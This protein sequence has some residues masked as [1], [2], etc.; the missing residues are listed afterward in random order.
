MARVKFYIEHRKDKDGKVKKFDV[1]IV[2]RYSFNRKRFEYYT[3]QRTDIDFYNVGYWKKRGD[4]QPIKYDAPRADAINTRLRE[5]ENL[6][7]DIEKDV[8][9]NSLTTDFLRKQLDIRFKDKTEPEPEKLTFYRYFEK[10]IEKTPNRVNKRTGHKISKDTPKKLKTVFNM[11]KDFAEFRGAEFDFN[12]VNQELYDELIG[13]MINEKKY[14]INTYGR[15]IKFIKT[16]LKDAYSNG[17]NKKIDFLNI[18]EGKTEE[19]DNIYLTEPELEKIFNL[20]LSG[21]PTLDRC[22][23]MFL[24]GCWTGLRFKDFISINKN[25]IKGDTIRLKS[26]KTK[27]KIVIPVHPIVKAIADKYKYVFPPAIS[28]QK[29]NL[30]LKEIAELAGIDEMFTKSITK[31]GK[32]VITT[33]HKYTCVSTHTARRSF[34]TNSYLRGIDTLLIMAITGHKTE[35]EFLKYIKLPQDEKAEKYKQQH[36]GY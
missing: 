33:K 30:Y 18:F 13:Y 34:A 7:S 26:H 2:L 19:S 15:T 22:R 16:V 17:I 23:D 6:I 27:S 10:Y 24:I 14:A 36:G 21:R 32:E 4:A 11:L 1:P 35:S 31:G 25:D 3:G 9:A 28:N 12:D 8:P 20:D 5:L 29:F